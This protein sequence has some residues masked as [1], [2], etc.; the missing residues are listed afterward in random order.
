MAKKIYREKYLEK[1]L[2]ESIKEMGLKALKFQS[3]SFTGMPD[4]LILLPNERVIWVEL[5]TTGEDLDAEQKSRKK[6]LEKIG[7][8]VYVVDDI[9]S[10][11]RVIG[12][13]LGAIE[14]EV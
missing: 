14:H 2:R 6:M 9:E 7:H 11:S 5:K 8:S 12:I 4:R 1:R 3:Q 13:V 10:L